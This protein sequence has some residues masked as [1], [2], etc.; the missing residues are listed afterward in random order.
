MVAIMFSIFSINL[1]NLRMLK[2][3][4]T[5]LEH[6][7]NRAIIF[8]WRRRTRSCRTCRRWGR[9]WSRKRRGGRRTLRTL[10]LGS[11]LRCTGRITRYWRIWKW[12]DRKEAWGGVGH[13]ANSRRLCPLCLN[14]RT[15]S[16]WTQLMKTP[17]TTQNQES[18]YWS[19][20]SCL[21]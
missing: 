8:R 1:G 9:W 13:R 2:Y 16:T 3:F 7:L 19:R 17:S 15:Q 5:L 4:S 14:S 12:R 6:N 11:S 10:S 20:G 18:S 21:T